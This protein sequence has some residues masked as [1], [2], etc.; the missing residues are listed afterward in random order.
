MSDPYNR[1]S[2]RDSAEQILLFVILPPDV[3][4]AEGEFLRHASVRQA[5]RA[6]S[7]SAITLQSLNVNYGVLPRP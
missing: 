5:S 1:S 7:K 6:R 3:C 4:R 2:I